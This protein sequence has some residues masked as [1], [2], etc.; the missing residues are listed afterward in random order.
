MC[1]HNGE[2]YVLDQ[3]RSILEQV[4]P[5]TRV[6]VHDYASTDNTVAYIDAAAQQSPIPIE[7][8][9]HSHA[10]GASL[11]FFRAL[12]L[13]SPEL[14]DNDLVMLCD[15]DDVWL[16]GKTA[17]MFG[18]FGSSDDGP[19]SV[20]VAFHDVQVVD[21]SL[22]ALRATYYGGNPWALPR[23]LDAE[24]LLLGSPVIGH[25]MTV[26][27]PLVKLVLRSARAERYLMHDWALVLFASR[28]GDIRFVPKVL[29]L[30]RQHASNVLG[31]YGRR[32]V[33]KTFSRVIRFSDAV[34][35]QALSFSADAA[36]AQSMGHRAVQMDRRLAES[37]GHNDWRVYAR[38]A[39]SALLRG[40]TPQRKGLGLFIVGHGLRRALTRQAR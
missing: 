29:S 14:G 39:L 4:P 33:W 2:A 5:V 13:L 8:N 11:S 30:Y 36:L 9:R 6:V 40:P 23:D 24:R 10:P 35:Q 28:F 21:Q 22:E 26:S 37:T 20:R 34:V 16:P 15:Q 25:T 38:L 31:A 27:A 3:L 12:D 17:A 18:A 7:V 19:M 32:S 1:C